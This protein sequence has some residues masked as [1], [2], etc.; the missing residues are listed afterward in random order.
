MLFLKQLTVK[1]VCLSL[2]LTPLRCLR[3]EQSQLRKLSYQALERTLQPMF[4]ALPKNEYG[5]LAP[6]TARYAV[7]RTF[8]HLHSWLIFGLAPEPENVTVTASPSA[9]LIGSDRPAEV[10]TLFRKH[11]YDAD[12]GLDLK[13]TIEFAFDLEK[14]VHAVAVVELKWAWTTFGLSPS[15][16]DAA[17]IE[18][19]YEILDLVMMALILK[20]EKEDR[21][22]REKVIADDP[23]WEQTKSFVRSVARSTLRTGQRSFTFSN[24]QRVVLEIVE[25]HG[26]WQS[27]QCLQIKDLLVGKERSCPGRVQLSSFYTEFYETGALPLVE[28]PR[29]LAALGALEDSATDHPSVLIPNYIQSAANYVYHTPFFAVVCPD[30]CAALLSRIEEHVAAPDA[31]PSVIADFVKSLPSTSQPDGPGSLPSWALERLQS[32]AMHHGG[33]IP[34][35]GRLF[36]QWLHGVYP[37]ECPFPQPYDSA[38]AIQLMPQA[39][40]ARSGTSRMADK[41]TMAAVIQKQVAWESAQEAAK[42]HVVSD[43]NETVDIHDDSYVAHADVKCFPWLPQEELVAPLVPQRLW[44]APLGVTIVTPLV[45]AFALALFITVLRV[46]KKQAEVQNRDSNATRN[47]N[48]NAFLSSATSGTQ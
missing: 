16:S 41:A 9:D 26:K 44:I 14:I 2:A 45:A 22:M 10:E 31:T 43:A 40:I 13:Q 21:A 30:E 47:A 7:H 32:G 24:V 38:T 23:Y 35:Q 19:V 5:K 18:G 33:R 12:G 39:F 1:I 20:E 28:S 29:Y 4:E 36:A 6:K 46:L 27:G 8:I 15:F 42:K 37:R 11:L 48:T 34:L 25:R 3:D 17:D